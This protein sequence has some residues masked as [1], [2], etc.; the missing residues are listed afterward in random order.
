MLELCWCT[1]P[2]SNQQA[3]VLL[4][5][6]LVAMG[7]RALPASVLWAQ[8]HETRCYVGAQL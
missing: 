2:A 5:F 3:H 8:L 6:V 1:Q 4:V 7:S